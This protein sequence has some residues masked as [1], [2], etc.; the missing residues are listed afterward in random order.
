MMR[1]LSS[2]F[3]AF[4][5]AISAVAS[6]AN[7]FEIKST[8]CCAPAISSS[9]IVQNDCACCFPAPKQNIPPKAPQTCFNST[10]LDFQTCATRFVYEW[11]KQLFIHKTTDRKKPLHLASNKIYLKKRALLI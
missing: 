9:Y 8:S 6:S 2:I 5:I 10:N 3:L 11:Q 1:Y 4:A 7:A